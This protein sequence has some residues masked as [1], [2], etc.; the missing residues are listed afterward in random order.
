MEVRRR[1]PIGVELVKRGIVTEEDIE[2]ALEYQKEHSTRKLGDILF[3]LN[4]CDAQDLINAIG[5]I[6]GTPGILLTPDRVKV[7]LTN[8]MSIDIA[9]QNKV[10][11]FDVSAGKVKVCFANTAN[12]RQIE[13]IRMLMLNKGLVMEKYI[14]FE[15]EI[16]RILKNF[17]GEAST[18]SAGVNATGATITSLIDSIIKT[19]MEKR[20]SDIHIEPMENQIRIRYRIDGVL[21]DAG[22]IPKDK[23]SQVIGRLKAISNMHQEKQISQDGRIVLYS[24]YNIRV[25]SQPN[26]Y[27]EKFVLRLL[28]KNADIKQIFDLGYPGDEHSLNKSINKRNS[29][30]IIAAPTGEGKTTTLYSIID[31]LNRPDINI[32]TIEDPVEIRISGLNQI[33]IDNAKSTFSGSLRTVL[34]QDPD[35]ILVGEIRDLETAEIAIQAGQTGH[36]VLSTIHTI[37]AIEVINR[38]RKLGVSDYDIASTL[39][40]AISQRLVRRLCPK[41]KRERDF[42]QEEKDIIMSISNK[43]NLGINLEGVK[44]YDAVGCKHCNKTGYYERVGVFETLDITDDI[45][46]LIVKGASTLEIRNKALEN[47]Y[48]PLIADGILKVVNG[49]TDL[50]EL[51]NKL[52]IF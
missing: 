18:D 50:K 3:I 21:V 51:N 8:Y 35:V 5:D 11:P 25:S 20:A 15:S 47:S 42:T 43:Y 7:D 19:G 49:I 22:T 6:V 26:I 33:E 37:D 10:V 46:D 13:T 30:T 34:R 2:K 32:T 41:C 38:L 16:E 9:K 39:A 36:Y 31:F 1:Q 40:T 48:R 4:L 12:N 28:K 27:G 14:T 17:E 29:I 52:I 24:D 23:Q 45:K 44:T